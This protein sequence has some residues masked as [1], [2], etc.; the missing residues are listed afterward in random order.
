MAFSIES[1]VPFLTPDL[2]DLAL[3]SPGDHLISP[4]GASKAVLRL[5]LR[6]LVPQSILDRQDKI[7]FSTPQATWFDQLR[8]W[9]AEVLSSPSAQAIPALHLPAIQAEWQRLMSRPPE[10]PWSLWRIWRWVNLIAWT[11]VFAVTF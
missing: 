10:T 3:S 9:I 11:E 2:A 5:A 8:P 4:A 7:G 6:G 1:R